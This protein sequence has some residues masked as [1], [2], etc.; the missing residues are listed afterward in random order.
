MKPGSTIKKG[1]QESPSRTKPF[2]SP[3]RE[4]PTEME[5]IDGMQVFTVKTPTECP[6]D[7]SDRPEVCQLALQFNWAYNQGGNV[8]RAFH[9]LYNFVITHT[10][11]VLR[12]L[13][14]DDC[15]CVGMAFSIIALE[16]ETVDGKRSVN[17]VAAENAY[18]CLM[19]SLRGTGDKSVIP[20][21]FSLLYG[22]ED[23]L[24]DAL[25]NC[26]L[27]QFKNAPSHGAFLGKWYDFGSPEF[28]R[29]AISYRLAMCKVLMDQVYDWDTRNYTINSL[30][31][32]HACWPSREQLSQ[33]YDEFIESPYIAMDYEVP[34]NRYLDGVFEECERVLMRY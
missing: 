28:R 29:S 2:V 22:P 4:E 18:Y 31:R 26:H 14:P 5:V 1:G 21:L 11:V 33:F 15:F 20:T 7:F 32:P 10:G 9:A 13:S 8:D 3:S 34:G 23:L 24:G 19:N 16:I 6:Y 30:G 17:S 25:T 12:E 27:R